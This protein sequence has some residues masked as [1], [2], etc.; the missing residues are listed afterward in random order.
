MKYSAGAP[1]CLKCRKNSREDQRRV[2]LRYGRR[3]THMSQTST[4]DQRRAQRLVRLN[5]RRRRAEQRSLGAVSPG[6]ARSVCFDDD[7]YTTIQRKTGLL[8]NRSTVRSCERSYVLDLPAPLKTVAIGALVC[9]KW[10]HTDGSTPQLYAGRYEGR[11]PFG[12][13]GEK[14]FPCITWWDGSTTFFN[15]CDHPVSTMMRLS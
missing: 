8:V 4:A 9:M 14:V 5:A 15:S 10:K 6:V 3:A 12:K 7:T 13:G 2:R 1:W 11:L